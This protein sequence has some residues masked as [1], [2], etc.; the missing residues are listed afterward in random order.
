MADW[1]GAV[2]VDRRQM[3]A[4]EYLRYSGKPSIEYREGVVVAKAWPTTYH[5]LLEFM[6]VMMLRRQGVQAAPEV[7][8]RLSPSKYL[9]PDVIAAHALQQPYPTEPVLL[10]CE[11]LSPE[12]KL[13]TM[14]AKCEEFHA[15]G[16]P[17]CWVVDP[18]KRTAWEYHREGEP[19]RVDAVLRAGGLSVEL[20][21]LFSALDLGQA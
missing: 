18:M 13:G 1:A 9:V 20:G 14:L 8:V 6:L 4:E 7:T 10:C 5:G 3:V 19:V 16:V 2:R 17:F 12:D 21:E 11:I 15:W